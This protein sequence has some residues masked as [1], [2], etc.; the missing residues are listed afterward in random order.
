[1]QCCKIGTPDPFWRFGVLVR[2]KL[3]GGDLKEE[4]IR[5]DFSL[6]LEYSH[7]TS[8]LLIKVGGDTRVGTPWAVLSYAVSSV[9]S[10]M[11][12]YP[13]LG[14]EAYLECTDQPGRR[15]KISSK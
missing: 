14:W 11:I 5:W 15:M 1:A 13:G 8:E 7:E 9:L 4:G 3:G 12:R 6:Q 10:M 2:G